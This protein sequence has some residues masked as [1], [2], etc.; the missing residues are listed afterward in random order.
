MKLIL[1]RQNPDN[2]REFAKRHN[3]PSKGSGSTVNHPYAVEPALYSSRQPC[4]CGPSFSERVG[5]NSA[6]RRPR[7]R[8]AYSAAL[9][10]TPVTALHQ[11]D[12]ETAVRS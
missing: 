7:G 11:Q 6:P 2:N 5:G 4:E 8:P 9:T 10:F 3:V 12:E 1:L